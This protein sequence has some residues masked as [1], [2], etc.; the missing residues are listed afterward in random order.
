M[1][2]TKGMCQAS[3]LLRANE[4]APFSGALMT[5]ETL[6]SLEAQAEKADLYKA[7]LDNNK[8]CLP[9]LSSFEPEKDHS[10]MLGAVVGIIFTGFI[11]LCLH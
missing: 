2:S 1:S 9:E 7:K 3:I 5:T 11:F 6:R 8:D 10:F 4:K